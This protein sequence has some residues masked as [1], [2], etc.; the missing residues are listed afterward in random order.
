MGPHPEEELPCLTGSHQ[1]GRE[2][3]RKFCQLRALGAAEPEKSAHATSVAGCY[4]GLW[5][6]FLCE[7]REHLRLVPLLVLLGY[8][9]DT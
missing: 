3:P 2:K 6:G 8:Q 9:V 4:L 7:H 5:E 1:L